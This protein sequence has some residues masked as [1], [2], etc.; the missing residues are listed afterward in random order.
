MSVC[1]SV[2]CFFSCGVGMMGWGGGVGVLGVCVAFFCWLCVFV[3]GAGVGFHH[4]I[5]SS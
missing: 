5:R 1:W 2:D 4:D 3:C